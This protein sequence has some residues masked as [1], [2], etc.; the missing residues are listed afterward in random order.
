MNQFEPA[1]VNPERAFCTQETNHMPIPHVQ[2]IRHGEYPYPYNGGHNRPT[3][4]KG[5]FDFPEINLNEPVMD[6]WA[7]LKIMNTPGH[8][9]R[10]L[11]QRRTRFV[12][13]TVGQKYLMLRLKAELAFEANNESSR[14][15]RRETGG[16]QYVDPYS[17][18]M[19]WM[20]D[21]D[22]STGMI[23]P[24]TTP[25]PEAIQIAREEALEELRMLKLCKY[26]VSYYHSIGGWKMRWP[27]L[28]DLVDVPADLHADLESEEPLE[29]RMG[30]ATHKYD[31][32][33]FDNHRLN[34]LAGG[35]SPDPIYTR[36]NLE[37]FAMDNAAVFAELADRKARHPLEVAVWKLA[38]FG[39][40]QIR[41]SVQNRYNMRPKRNALLEWVFTPGHVCK[42]VMWANRKRFARSWEYP[43]IL[44]S[45]TVLTHEPE[46][47]MYRRGKVKLEGFDEFIAFRNGRVVS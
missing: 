18:N 43:W 14:L 2:F 40:L 37:D 11:I 38:E 41:Q 34:E 24:G 30:T 23:G 9:Q 45:I 26:K 16:D 7:A 12:Q 42:F 22:M 44:R 25:D 17:E 13:R 6:G 8:P 39:D 5:A 29:S 15:L 32:R 47:W 33:W 10:E 21:W 28:G 3:H 31:E 27:K 35:F 4:R 20:H 19:D 1:L 36:I 46:S